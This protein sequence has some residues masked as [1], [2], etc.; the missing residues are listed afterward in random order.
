MGLRLTR[1]H[2]DKAMFLVTDMVSPVS[3]LQ[4]SK[5]ERMYEETEVTNR[6]ASY[7]AEH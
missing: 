4:A 2:A 1:L 6:D 5:K 7:S 3:I